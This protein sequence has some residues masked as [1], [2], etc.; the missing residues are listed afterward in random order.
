MAGRSH[1]ASGILNQQ[2]WYLDSFDLKG[3]VQSNMRVDRIPV[4]LEILV[5]DGA[6]P[7]KRFE[8]RASTLIHQMG[9][10]PSSR[11]WCYG[12]FVVVFVGQFGPYCYGHSHWTGNA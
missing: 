11:A 10:G 1:S 9:I 12:H 7:V 6:S 3:K 8:I 4:S 2:Q 5:S